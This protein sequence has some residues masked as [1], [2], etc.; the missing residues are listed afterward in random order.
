MQLLDNRLMITRRM[1]RERLPSARWPYGEPGQEQRRK[2]LKFHSTFDCSIQVWVELHTRKED[3]LEWIKI[4]KLDVAQKASSCV[5]EDKHTEALTD[6]F[7]GGVFV[8]C[9]LKG[10]YEKTN[11]IPKGLKENK[12]WDSYHEFNEIWLIFLTAT[13]SKVFFSL[14]S[15]KK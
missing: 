2:Q 14:L 5:R 15:F 1:L 11:G 8:G 9:T 3:K 12:C 10:K 4:P 6:G 7:R 13:N